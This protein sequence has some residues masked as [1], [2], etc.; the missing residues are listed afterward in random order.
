MPS[1]YRSSSFSHRAYVVLR[2][3]AAWQK[4]IVFLFFLLF[5]YS[6]YYLHECLLA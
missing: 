2:S 3:L 1:S 5:F 4:I 6:L